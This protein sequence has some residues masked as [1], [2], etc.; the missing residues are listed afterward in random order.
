MGKTSL[1]FQRILLI[2]SALAVLGV[3][4]WGGFRFFEPVPVPP[5][6]P[7][8]QRVSFDPNADIRNHPFWE[9]LFAVFNDEVEPGVLGRDNPFADVGSSSTSRD[10]GVPSGLG[11]VREVTL[12][13]GQALAIA[14]AREGGVLVLVVSAPVSGGQAYEIRRMT[15]TDAPVVLANWS[16]PSTIGQSPATTPVAV[17]QDGEGKLWVL[18]GNGA[19]TSITGGG[20]PDVRATIALTTTNAAVA[21]LYADIRFDG[22]GRMWVTDGISVAEG[23]NGSFRAVDMPAQLS[24]ADRA[25]LG[26]TGSEPVATLNDFFRPWRFQTRSDGRQVVF[27]PKAIVTFPLDLQARPGVRVA[28]SAESILAVTPQ[29]D[30]WATLFDSAFSM[31]GMARQ[32][33]QETRSF[34]DPVVLPKQAPRNTYL[35]SMGPGSLIALDYQAGGTVLWNDAGGSWLA[36]VLAPVG[37]QPPD[38]VRRLVADQQGNVWAILNQKGLLLAMPPSL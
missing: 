12:N 29:G 15:S 1:L 32:T 38:A 9:G 18:F 13:G 19:V 2:L 4:M 37:T 35:M 23:G 27:S 11:T 28:A 3:A 14:P 25:A 17:G 20:G 36:Q 6:P 30:S 34:L 8:K 21:P 10:G 33:G 5:I 24:A 22:A 26:L 16:V 31:R 7:P